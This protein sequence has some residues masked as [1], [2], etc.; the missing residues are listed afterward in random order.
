MNYR[1]IRLCALAAALV[2]PALPSR[3]QSGALSPCGFSDRVENGQSVAAQGR[4]SV[5][6]SGGLTFSL[7]SS[8]C[9][10][11][12]IIVFVPEG[13]RERVAARC[14]GRQ[15]RVEGT[16]MEGCLP[17]LMSMCGSTIDMRRYG[18]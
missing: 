17:F 4:L 7:N 14:D 1:N 3:A 13:A 10:G 15:T 8:R 6:R 18:C 9:P 11:D 16:V 12:T 2:L 5:S